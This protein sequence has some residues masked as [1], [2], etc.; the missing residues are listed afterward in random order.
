MRESLD[1]LGL[2][3]R[4]AL[5]VVHKG[6]P[7][8]AHVLACR[9]SP[10]TGLAAFSHCTQDEFRAAGDFEAW[11]DAPAGRGRNGRR[12]YVPQVIAHKKKL[13]AERS[14]PWYWREDPVWG[15]RYREYPYG[16]SICPDDDAADRRRFEF[17]QD[18]RNALGVAWWRRKLRER[19]RRASD[20]AFLE[21]LDGLE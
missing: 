2:L 9:V 11:Y 21:L 19:E 12:G 18:A 17:L 7:W 10:A 4:Q 1:R 8:H 15:D 13:L 6:P 16:L 14:A 5:V 3:D 20:R